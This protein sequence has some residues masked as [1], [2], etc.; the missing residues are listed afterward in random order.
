MWALSSNCSG[1]FFWRWWRWQRGVTRYY[2]IRDSFPV[3]NMH[4]CYYVTQKFW[5][6]FHS[7]P[8]NTRQLQSFKKFQK[9]SKSFK[10]CLYCIYLFKLYAKSIIIF[11]TSNLANIWGK[12]REVWLILWL[13]YTCNV[14]RLEEVKKWG[15][16]ECTLHCWPKSLKMSDY[17]RPYQQV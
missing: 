6:T 9:V 16:N 14:K 4:V 15:R 7:Y 11:V 13:A 8:S 1:K 3:C 10:A 17:I 2:G 5:S 12:I